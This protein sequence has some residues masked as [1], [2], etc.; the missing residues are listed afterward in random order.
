MSKFANVTDLK[1]VFKCGKN[2]GDNIILKKDYSIKTNDK[3]KIP[4]YFFKDDQFK[5]I[6]CSGN[7]IK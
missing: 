4:Y 2:D 7:Q 6:E 3:K 5:V 1:E